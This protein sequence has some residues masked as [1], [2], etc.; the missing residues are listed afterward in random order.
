MP[1]R[2]IKKEDAF[3]DTNW[4]YDVGVV[5]Q[6]TEAERSEAAAYIRQHASDPE[7]VLRA[8]GLS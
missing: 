8:L 6:S 4:Q 3:S 5:P 2:P 7:T 1:K